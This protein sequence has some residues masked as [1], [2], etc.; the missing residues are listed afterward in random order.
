M[1][2]FED[3]MQQTFLPSGRVQYFPLCEYEK[4]GQFTH[5]LSGEVYQVDY[6]INWSIAPI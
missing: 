6:T 3:V 5:K 2:Y 4:D 1:T